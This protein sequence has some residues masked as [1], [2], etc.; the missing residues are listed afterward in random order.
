MGLVWDKNSW[1]MHY[2]M[3]WITMRIRTVTRFFMSPNR[4]RNTQPICANLQEAILTCYN[5][6]KSQVLNCSELVKEY[7]RCV[8]LA[9]KVTIA[10]YSIYSK[11]AIVIAQVSQK[12]LPPLSCN[13]LPSTKHWNIGSYNENQ[14]W[15]QNKTRLY[16]SAVTDNDYFSCLLKAY[17][18]EMSFADRSIL[19]RGPAESPVEEG[20]TAWKQPTQM[21]LLKMEEAH[22]ERNSPSNSH[23]PSH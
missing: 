13:A 22:M 5:E 16:K 10:L 21:V 6:N 1:H 3:Y 7:Q 4:R 18:K 11:E 8:R 2:L 9:Q 15:K 12:D 20:F 23:N 19:G 17:L 14:V